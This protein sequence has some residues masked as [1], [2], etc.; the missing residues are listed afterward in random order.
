MAEKDLVIIGAGP[1]GLALAC[2][3]EGKSR[4]LERGTEPGGLCRSIELDGAMFDIGG[5][6]FHTPHEEVREFVETL[7]RG[8]W[9]SQQRDARVF[10]DGELIPY[11]FQAHFDKLGDGAV[12][13]D[14]RAG[15]GG[16][17][18]K[19]ANFEEWIVARFGEGVA[20]HFMLPYNRKLWARDLR[21]MSR[22]WVGERV[23]SP[24]GEKREPGGG[25]RKPLQSDSRVAYPTQGGFGA[26][27]QRMAADCAP[28][29]YGAEIVRVDVAS[30]TV[31]S[32]DGRVWR[33]QRLASTMPV[34]LLLRAVDGVP[35]ELRQQ[36]EK[37]EQVALRVLMIVVDDP[38]PDA[39]QRVYVADSAVPP[40]KVAFNHTSSEAL[41]RRPVH[42]IMC[43]ISHS[44][45]KPLPS[46]TG[47]EAATVDW[48]RGS[49]L[50]PPHAAI[51][52]ILHYDVSYGYPV[53]THERPAIMA[54]IRAWLEP[55]GI[56]TLG[57]FGAWDYANS[58]E[59]IRQGMEL[60]RRL[61]PEEAR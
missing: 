30:K 24:A 52:R 37:L 23:A 61:S 27:L 35:P 38:L 16:D 44:A 51:T 14:C 4:I 36:A 22:E 19:A 17:T 9:S 7:M 55:R 33:W 26:I 40:H 59:C 49:G 31:E 58:D 41:R 2:H 43:E 45:E 53:Y 12:V 13:A 1:A 10:F 42:A 28:I 54:G 8:N 46:E 50:V 56:H 47:L 6:S 11:P 20:R 25:G 29:E 21:G 5:H 3:Y 32:T 18:D 60:G 34:P 48:L 57:R 39:P 15:R